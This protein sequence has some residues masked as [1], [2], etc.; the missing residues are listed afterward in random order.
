M[1]SGLIP[2]ESVVDRW[3]SEGVL[4]TS[5]SL[6]LEFF[7]LVQA[8][9]IAGIHKFNRA[10]FVKGVREWSRFIKRRGVRVSPG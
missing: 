3:F 7:G 5:G 10:V 6:L 2:L 8:D 4:G 1:V 9:A